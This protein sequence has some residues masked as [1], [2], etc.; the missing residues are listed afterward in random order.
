M[1]VVTFSN[2]WFDDIDPSVSAF[3]T[4]L[5]VVFTAIISSV[6]NFRLPTKS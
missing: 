6:Y 3:L 4:S 5:Y 1:F 2:D